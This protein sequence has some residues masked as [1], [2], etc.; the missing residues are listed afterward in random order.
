VHAQSESFVEPTSAGLGQRAIPLRVGG[1]AQ[2]LGHGLP[3]FEKCE[4][5][6]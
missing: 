2:F 3:R 4:I 6:F 1:G 5:A